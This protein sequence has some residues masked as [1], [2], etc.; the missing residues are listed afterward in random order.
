[1]RDGYVR[2]LLTIIAAALV[3]LV[4]LEG[5]W[6]PRPAAAPEA[7]PAGRYQYAPLRYG[8]LGNF[9]VR[10]DSATGKLERVRF[11]AN[12]VVWE[13]VGVLPA[14]KAAKSDPLRETP[15]G[16]PG[17]PGSGTGGGVVVGPGGVLS[18]AAPPPGPPGGG[19]G[20]P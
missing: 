7:P 9:L 5:G 10:F 18:P 3:A 16:L 17:V 4:L 2:L 6:L 13:E 14:G 12:D 1:M 20:A 11:P 15:P 19:A 8:P